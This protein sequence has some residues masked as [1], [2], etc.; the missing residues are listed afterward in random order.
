MPI[1]V[2]LFLFL[3]FGLSGGQLLNRPPEF[4][5]GGD[6][7]GLVVNENTP[8]G[9]IVYTLK[10][11]DPEGQRVFYYISGDS[12]SVDKDSGAVKLIKPLDR[13]EEPV[14]DVIVTVTDEK[15]KNTR[16]NTV[17]VQREV[18]VGDHND[19]V[20]TFSGTPYGVTV[21]E[22]THP[23]T[24]VFDGIFVTDAD[25]GMNAQVSLDCVPLTSSA[26]DVFHVHTALLAEGKYRGSISLK[27]ASLNYEAISQYNMTLLARDRGGL[28]STVTVT[29]DVLDVQ[30]ELPRFVDTPYAISAHES[31][32]PETPLL[33]IRARDGD[34]TPSL[35]RPLKLS[36]VRDVKRYF[37]LRQMEED[38]WVLHTTQQPIDREDRDILAAG[39][40]YEIGV[41]AVE[42][43][44]GRESGDFS[45]ENITITILDV[46][47]QNPTFSVKTAQLPISEDISNGSFVPD[48]ELIVTDLDS[49]ENSKFTLHL[50]DLDVNNPA[51]RV[52]EVSPTIV[53]GSGKVALKVINNLLIDYEN[54][55]KRIFEFN[56]VAIE[57]EH[58][59]LS[60]VTLTV[61][62]ANDHTP[63]FDSDQ[64][65]VQVPENAPPNISIFSLRA[66]DLDSNHFGRVTYSIEG[67]GSNRFFVQPQTGDIGVSP[68]EDPSDLL[69]TCLDFETQPTYSLKYVATDGGGRQSAVTLFIEV[70]DVNDNLPI[71]QPF[72]TTV[73]ILEGDRH[74]TPKLFLRATDRDGPAQGGN[75][76]IRYFIKET[77]LTSLIVDAVTGEVKLNE[78]AVAEFSPVVNGTRHKINYEATIR[79][80]DSGDTPLSSEVKV[81][82]VV[83]SERDGAPF[84]LEEPYTATIREDAPGGTQVLRVTASDPDGDDSL[85]RYTIVAGSKGNFDINA[86]T[87]AISVNRDAILDREQSGNAY[88][89]TVA[90]ID[91]NQPLPLMT[92]TIAR[93]NIEDSNNKPPI[94]SPESYVVFITDRDLVVGRDVVR[95]KAID[96]DS[97]ALLKFAIDSS[98]VVVRDRTGFPLT[99]PL[100]VASFNINDTTGIISVAQKLDLLKAAMFVI[101]VIV[102]DE[103]ATP[104]TAPQ[105]ARTEVTIYIQRDS[106]QNPVFAAPWSSTH[107][108]YNVQ[109][110]EETLVGSTIMTLSAKDSFTGNRIVDFE[111]VAE[112]DPN[113]FFTVERSS[114]VVSINRRLDFED[115]PMKQLKFS[116][117][118]KSSQ[119][120][121]GFTPFSIANIIVDVQ[122]INDHS[123]RFSQEEYSVTIPEDTKWPQVV[124]TVTA[125]DKDSGAFGSIQFSLSGDGSHMFDID[126]VSGSIRVREDVTLDR[127]LRSVYVLQVT[128]TDNASANPDGKGIVRKST[129][130]VAR[131]HLSD[132]NDNSPVFEKTS[133]EG[134]IPENVPEGFVVGRV[135]ATDLD[136]GKNGKVSYEILG[137]EETP[138]RS[139]FFC[140]DSDSGIITVCNV[141]SGK[142]RKDPYVIEIR[143]MD[144]GKPQR[145]YSDVIFSILVGD[146]SANDGVPVILRPLPGEVLLIPEN[147]KPGTFIYQVE[148]IDPDNSNHPN[149]KVMFKFADPVLYFDIDPVSGVITT[150][151]STSSSNSQRSGVSSSLV[152]D[153]ERTENFTLI[154]VAYDLGL[155]PQ[156][157]HQVIHIRVTDVDDN[158]AVFLRTRDSPPL[159]FEV[160]EEVPIGT[161]VARIKAVD[162]DAGSN[163]LVAYEIIHG[164]Q[165]DIFSISSTHDGDGVIKAGKRLD[166]EKED[167]FLLTI[168]AGHP[169]RLKTE[170][171]L[172]KYAS[173]DKNDASQIQVEILLKDIDDNPPAFEQDS[174]VV[175]VK[176]SVDVHED[177]LTF[178]ARDP[179]VT[180][181]S[182]DIEYSIAAAQYIAGRSVRENVAQFFELDPSSGVLRNSLSLRSFVGGHFNLTIK[183]MNKH[184]GHESLVVKGKPVVAHVNCKIFIV[185][186]KDFLKFTFNRRPD[187]INKSMK[188][189]QKKVAQVLQEDGESLTYSLN[190]DQLQFL[191][192][193]DGSLDFESTNACFQ[194]I[195][196]NKGKS[197]IVD[198]KEG[199]R[200]LSPNQLVGHTEVLRRVYANFGVVSVEECVV[201]RE[202]YRLSRSEIGLILVGL[203][204]AVATVFLI[205]VSSNMRRELK[206]KLRGPQPAFVDATPVY[207]R[208]PVPYGVPFKAPSFISEEQQ[209]IHEWQEE[210]IPPLDTVS[211]RSFPTIK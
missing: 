75:E 2:Y 13:E 89:L 116:V 147:S 175:G 35:R 168:K 109:V 157:T 156:E 62:D 195:K 39:G 117:R 56:I 102:R 106:A 178:R 153:R 203:F 10:A 176:Y 58:R 204:I 16:P 43:V 96:Q 85:I 163:A 121:G 140:I 114:G 1:L 14:L 197:A 145:L 68:C 110:P 64:Y 101:P 108:E 122:D 174:Y 63:S 50:E 94:F 189:L 165:Q 79:A 8:V 24:T 53:S 199:L 138:Q 20:P 130:V 71:F 180:Q 45:F 211:F 167:K 166:R 65:M 128:A 95:V 72:N 84:F 143:A 104:A 87:G 48:L 73:E 34:A 182:A 181:A 28:N 46:N 146:I 127:E 187:E 32:P 190:F 99:E 179:D 129:S 21:S 103:N 191:E 170:I 136:E 144:H 97:D 209:R 125:A 36:L 194:L 120:V 77:N 164:N 81:T 184:T 112:S 100:L 93:V 54:E 25:V 11:K 173:Y 161:E 15:A 26:C 4:L 205:C 148:A 90:V 83:R 52:F 159:V 131:I 206:E 154:L 105:E 196:T 44:N 60:H 158:D 23:F 76:G 200:A 152:L 30:D 98:G 47:D 135:K 27:A 22:A 169:K 29:I 59:T 38:V 172:S 208:S 151:S 88:D 177:I 171:S 160:E 37:D 49:V 107:P 70:L 40:I 113:N 18:K 193:K 149:G 188:D 134:N 42:L 155:P 118:A 86:V 132:I 6:L 115:L 137:F 141:L 133:Y 111:K 183:A 91:S 162:A 69:Q 186:E 17:S 55:E 7:N 210:I 82:F 126:P 61:I 51:S 19:N 41:R 80:V 78:P 12:F 74:S 192:R 67:S 123:P 124:L 150:S 92:T 207:V 185:K 3:L 139:R 198:Q 5:P 202:S 66:A 119:I 57:G 33:T 9:T 142:G 201:D 31:L